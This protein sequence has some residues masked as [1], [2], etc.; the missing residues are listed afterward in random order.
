MPETNFLKSIAQY[1]AQPAEGKPRRDSL[2]FVLPNKRSAMFLKKYVAETIRGV[3]MMPQFMTMQTFLSLNSQNPDAD[4]DELLFILYDSYRKVMEHRGQVETSRQFD[5]FVFWGSMMLSDFDDIDKSMV[6]ANDLFKNL[7]NVKEIQ[8]DY[9]TDEQKDVVRRIWGESRLT[10]HVDQFWLHVSGGDASETSMSSKF[11][12]LWEILADI[13]AEF[14]KQLADKGVSSVGGLFRQTVEKFNKMEPYDV[15]PDRHYVFVGFN[16]LSTAET[17]I[18]ERLQKLKSA[19]FFWDLSPLRLMDDGKEFA[20]QA[21]PLKRLQDLSKHFPQPSDYELAEP[22]TRPEVC[23]YSVPSNNGQGKA[24]HNILTDWL[25]DNSTNKFN[26]INTAIVLPDQNLLLPTLFSLPEEIGAV[27]IS[28][29][30]SFK[31]TTFAGL[32][33]S[34]ISMQLRARE[35][36]NQFHYFY[37]DITA[38]LN[39]PHLRAIAP[40][41]ADEIQSKIAE[42]KLYNVNALLLV[43]DYPN[44]S[45]IFSPVHNCNNVAQVSEYLITLLDFLASAIEERGKN[46]GFEVKAIHYF[47]EQTEKLT[48]LIRRYNVEMTDK[49][50]LH[51]FEKLFNNRGLTVSGT[52]LRGLQI[53]GVLETRGLDFDN[54]IVL[55]MNEQIFPKK[56]YTKTMIPNNLRLGYGLPDFENLEWTYA[57][58]FYRLIS[59]AKRVA[60][61]YDSRSEGRGKGEMSRYLSQMQYLMPAI[62][63]DIKSF[64]YLS[65]PVDEGNIEIVKDEVVMAELNEFRAGGSLSLSA[66]AL[67]DFKKCSLKFYLCYAKRFRNTNE[68]VDYVTAAEHG[69]IIHSS[70]QDIYERYKGQVIDAALIENWI[71]PEN[72]LISEIVRKNLIEEH[73][74]SYRNNPENL[75]SEAKITCEIIEAVVRADLKAELNTYCNPSFVFEGTEVR[76]ETSVW[77]IEPGLEVNFKMFIDRVD[78]TNQGLRFVDFKTGS[79]KTSVSSVSNLFSS[80]H[81]TD[82]IF[83]LLTYAEAYGKMVD[84]NVEIEP[85]IHPTRVLSANETIPP[86]VINKEEIHSYSQIADEFR[87]KINDLIKQIFDPSKPLKQCEKASDCAYCPFLTL[88]GRVVPEY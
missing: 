58:C 61:L 80:S 60:L 3:A 33:R 5:S 75:P 7:K 51:L 26:P 21:I 66:S 73:Y 34:I 45:A 86:I 9:L 2:M 42:R 74:Y 71:A 35:I 12:F 63:P 11:V 10:A 87:P 18:F 88:C 70:I 23:I 31:S 17:L 67:K 22:C 20:K 76:P 43:Q 68:L 72:P 62:N 85:V 16:D 49:T 19:S 36:N 69:N 57:Y 77:H 32:L 52:P 54:V 46:P 15:T 64:S 24:V 44:L 29:G 28:M 40:E 30:L 37:E 56:Q 4:N 41:E 65:D 14:K 13:Y 82:G 38:V 78:K 53:L 81:S 1:Y 27:N 55:S 59:R 84:A 48:G 47:K 79:D 50:F 6:N 83:Q 25:K 39:H 8:A